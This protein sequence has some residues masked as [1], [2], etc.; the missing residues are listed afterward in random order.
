MINEKNK[1]A[2]FYHIRLHDWKGNLIDK[3]KFR[4]TEKNKACL[5]IG[6]IMDNCNVSHQ[7]IEESKINE[8]EIVETKRLPEWKKPI[9]WKRDSRGNII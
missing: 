8:N 5:I 9:I 6:R 3:Q 2:D 7:D 4:T 1:P